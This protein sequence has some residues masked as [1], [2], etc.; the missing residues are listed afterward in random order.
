MQRSQA[1]PQTAGRT[2]PRIW[3]A[4][5]SLKEASGMVAS[6]PAKDVHWK[7]FEFHRNRPALSHWAAEVWPGSHMAM[8]PEERPARQTPAAARDL[9]C[10]FLGPSHPGKRKAQCDSAGFCLPIIIMMQHRLLT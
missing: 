6:S 7:S 8:D 10:A 1:S 9:R 2:D 4:C 5:L 3:T